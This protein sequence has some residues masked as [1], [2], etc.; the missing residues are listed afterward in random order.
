MDYSVDKR[1][2][3]LAA[4]A[5]LIVQNGLNS[6]MSAIAEAAG[7]ATGSLYNYFSS[8]EELIWAVYKRLA[9]SIDEALVRPIDPIEPHRQRFIN[10]FS[11]YI[12]FIWADPDRAILFEYLSN[13]PIISHSELREVFSGSS[14]YIGRLISDA[15]KAGV[16][17]RASTTLIGALLGGA[18]RNSLKWQRVH[19]KPLTRKD[20]EELLQMCWDA[21]AA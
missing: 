17:R 2:R 14:V 16:V 18:I 3:I 19:D 20:R 1:E 21:I 5:K 9:K 11:D 12:D 8:K 6:P 15:Q 13:A 10:Y 7:V 4:T